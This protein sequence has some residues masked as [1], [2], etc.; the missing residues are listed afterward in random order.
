MASKREEKAKEFSGKTIQMD[1]TT[2]IRLLF[3]KPS[4]FFEKVKK[5][6]IILSFS[7]FVA[8]LIIGSF[9]SLIVSNSILVLV[10]SI[11]S[12]IFLFIYYITTHIFA[13]LLG[14]R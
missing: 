14:G 6:E 12:V 1:F 4:E 11:T 3:L 2:R 7:L 9:L 13:Y 8:V 5:E 10:S